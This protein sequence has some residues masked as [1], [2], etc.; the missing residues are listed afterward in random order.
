MIAWLTRAGVNYTDDTVPR[1]YVVGGNVILR[2]SP[3]ADVAGYALHTQRQSF[4]QLSGTLEPILT[5]GNTM[6]FKV[7]P[8]DENKMEPDTS[9]PQT[10]GSDKQEN[11]E[12][13]SSN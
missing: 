1:R 7:V 5:T 8:M 13:A 3:P 11:A 9:N 2:K 12:D 10:T 6:P 4:A